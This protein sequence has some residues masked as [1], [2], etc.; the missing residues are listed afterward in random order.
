MRGKHITIFG[1]SGFV[2]RYIVQELAEQGAIIRVGVRNI[3]EA[4]FLKPMGS[5]GQ[6]TPISI[7]LMNQNSVNEI[8]KDADILINCV[9]ILTESGSRKFDSIHHMG[10]Q[11]I[12]RAAQE[13]GIEN[14]IHLSAIGANK[15]SKSIYAQ[16]KAKGEEALRTIFPKSIIIRPSIVF[17]SEDNFFNLFAQMAQI[18]F[19]LPLI[20]GGNTQFQPIYVKDIA[21]FVGNLLQNE[22]SQG[23]TYEIGGPKTYS[24]KE[25]MQIMLRYIER[26]R[27]LL[28][29]PFGFAKFLSY[30]LQYLP[31]KL[32]TPDQVELLKQD[33]VC[34]PNYPGLESQNVSP[35]PLEIILP[36]YLSRYRPGG[37][38][39]KM[40]RTK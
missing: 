33:N 6:I 8:S 40:T 5:V 1:G 28:S 30:F 31:G 20:G 7:D 14:L 36:A 4:N 12:A 2:G 10:V 32:I 19:F 24:F 27:Y 11:N 26:K 9:G 29:I 15:D 38:Y 17:G 16:S 23:I 37:R 25:L 22:A 13:N 18:S 34:N 39:I 3:H 21:H 35:T